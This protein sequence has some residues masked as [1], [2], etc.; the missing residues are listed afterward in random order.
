MRPM[1]PDQRKKLARQAL[2][3]LAD[4]ATLRRDKR[5]DKYHEGS[6]DGEIVAAHQRCLVLGLRLKD[7]GLRGKYR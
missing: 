6:S 1:T 7:A 4:Y 2:E 3:A 5:L